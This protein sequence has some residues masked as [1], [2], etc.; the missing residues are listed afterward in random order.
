MVGDR[1]T[2]RIAMWDGHLDGRVV[3]R[4][5]GIV[6]TAGRMMCVWDRHECRDG[7][8]LFSWGGI[9]LVVARTGR[10]VAGGRMVKVCSEVARVVQAGQQGLLVQADV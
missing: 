3:F 7:Q 5:A 8:D 2:G 10:I 4:I 6:W 1:R 9:V